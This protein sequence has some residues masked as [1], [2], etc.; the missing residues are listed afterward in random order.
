MKNNNF[1]LLKKKPRKL[2]SLLQIKKLLLSGVVYPLLNP[3]LLTGP[4]ESSVNP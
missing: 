1:L 3:H 4:A 2:F